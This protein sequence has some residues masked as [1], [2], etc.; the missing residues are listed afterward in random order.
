MARIPD[1]I[2]EEPVGH[3]PV[4]DHGQV[5]PHVAGRP[6]VRPRDEMT[7][8]VQGPLA[9]ETKS[10]RPFAGSPVIAGIATRVGRGNVL[11]SA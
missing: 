5:G 3:A 8:P 4:A 2:E 10:V 6:D 1:E 11:L 9:R 7:A